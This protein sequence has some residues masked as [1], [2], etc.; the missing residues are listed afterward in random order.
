MYLHESFARERN[1][2]ASDEMCK[3]NK[4]RK[5][6]KQHCQQVQYIISIQDKKIEDRLMQTKIQNA[7]NV[8]SILYLV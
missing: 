2:I 1:R 7:I 5:D 4:V 6:L 3:L 8:H